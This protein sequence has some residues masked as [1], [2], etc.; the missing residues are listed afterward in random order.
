[1]TSGA[2]FKDI[3]EKIMAKHE[4]MSLAQ[5]KDT[6]NA[7]LPTIKNGNLNAMSYL[8]DEMNINIDNDYSASY[9]DKE[10][11]WGVI[12]KDSSRYTFRKL[13][14]NDEFVPN[15]TGMG[16][17]DAVYLMKKAGLK[18][19]L[20]G[21]GHVVKQSIKPGTRAVPGTQITLTLKP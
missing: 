10:P 14:T 6:I 8:L 13:D 1:M 18:T 5:G 15:V 16:A 11:E 20:N 7:L 4:R 21:Y 3:A 9:D 2:V 17:K 19:S 12:K